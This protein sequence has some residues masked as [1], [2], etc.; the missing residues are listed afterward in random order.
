M[1]L[2]GL[3]STINLNRQPIEG[4]I[5]MSFTANL[6]EIF[7]IVSSNHANPHNILG[8]HKVRFKKKDMLAI[9]LFHPG[10]KEVEVVRSDDPSE[11][12]KMT[13]LHE[14]GFFEAIIDKETEFFDYQYNFTGYDDNT[15]QAYD[16]YACAPVL[17]DFDLYLF[18]K[19]THYE[20]HKKMGA[21]IIEHEGKKGVL[22]TVWAPN[23]KRVSIIGDF[24]A[25]DGRTNPMRAR[26]NSGVYELFIP[27][28]KEGEKY[29]FEIKS[30]DGRILKKSDP[31]G[32]YSE[33]RPNTASVVFDISKY[34][35]KDKK[36]MEK[37]KDPSLSKPINIYEVHLGSWKRIVE[38][39]NRHMTYTEL[40]ESLVKYV[41]EMG[42]THI[43][44]MPV[45]EYPFDGSWGYQVA[46]YFAVTSRFG[47]PTEFKHFVDVCHQ[48]DIGV[49]LDWVPAHF[50]KDAHGL[51]QFDG[52]PLYEHADPRKGE[53][54]HWGTLIFNYGRN[55]VKS[56]LIG[57][58]LFW[59]EEYH[60]DGLRVDAV[61][62]M[63]Y[64]DYGKD[65]GQWVAN[66][67]G[68]KENNEAIEF[69][70]HM[71]S[72]ILGKYPGILMIAEE[73][74]A[75]SGV[76][77]AAEYG[78]LG[79]RLKWNMGWMNDFLR[80]ISKDPIYRKYNHNDL[81]FSM[82][83]AYT[84]NFTLVLSHDEVVHGK[85][86]MIGKMPGDLWQKFANLRAAYSFMYTHPGKKL[87]FMGSEFGQF[88]EWNYEKSLDWHLLEYDSHKQLK[89]FM[90][91]LNHLY[92]KEK[93]LWYD[94]FSHIGFEW[95]NVSDY[96][97][98]LVAFLRKQEDYND[99]V[100]CVVNF[101]PVPYTEHRIGV[102]LSGN[103]KE[104][105]NSDNPKY[106][107]SGIL[108][109]QIITADEMEWD[110]R[111]YSIGLKVPPLGMTMLKKVD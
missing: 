18:N 105:I 79:F 9:R 70:K 32:N 19:G 84:E 73:S 24:N 20:I 15:W 76:S 34:K 55:E 5:K 40:S 94:D 35:W 78:G 28:L 102:P 103:Y 68:G 100:I 107:G 58:A 17:S 81:T 21:H 14:D 31:Y 106:G 25:W 56:F 54:P 45:S 12:Y 60:V 93:S 82:V 51:A 69:I 46:G 7:Q 104:I 59:L 26:E 38:D 61:A 49:I 53:H 52:T 86:S 74:T 4:R 41:K 96:E 3:N 30:Q 8:M 22:F 13:K 101:T 67:Y 64:L 1:P 91:D 95:I 65:S 10:C 6:T 33:L 43:E 99:A 29:K 80:Y 42:Y 110:G 89:E 36:W 50:P 11:T 48:N 44:L 90:L 88:S 37:R 62:S 92:L 87:L 77:R 47:T 97:K 98:S 2:L 39:D 71:N 23:A 16:P 27:G 109:T 72:V 111:Q 85:G 108:N 75:F 63:L 83:Y 66:E 57:N